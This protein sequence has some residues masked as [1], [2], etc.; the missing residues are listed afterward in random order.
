MDKVEMSKVS[1][2]LSLLVDPTLAMLAAQRLYATQGQGLCHS[3]WLGQTVP[4]G[5][6]A[7]PLTQLDDDDG[8]ADD[9]DDYNDVDYNDD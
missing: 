9:D 2:S 8:D 7:A 4:L 3:G 6:T 5:R 1:C